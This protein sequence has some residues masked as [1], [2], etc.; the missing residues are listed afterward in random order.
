MSPDHK[1]ERTMKGMKPMIN[2]QQRAAGIRTP[3][4]KA[5]S[6]LHMRMWVLPSMPSRMLMGILLTRRTRLLLEQD[7]SFNTTLIMMVV[8]RRYM[9]PQVWLGMHLWLGTSE[10]LVDCSV[11]FCGKKKEPCVSP[12]QQ[13]LPQCC[14]LTPM[15][16]ENNSPCSWKSCSL[17]CSF[18]VV[19]SPVVAL[20]RVI[21]LIHHNVYSCAEK[22]TNIIFHQENNK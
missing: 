15:E 3:L 11:W 8:M 22:K 7:L 10:Q 13:N 1:Q 18:Q 17:T 2:T 16:K 5:A 9:I 12:T 20:K 19:H 14:V 4:L 6:P 21:L